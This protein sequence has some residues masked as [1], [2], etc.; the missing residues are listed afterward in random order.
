M[1]R[2][3]ISRVKS[4]LGT[5]LDNRSMKKT[6]TAYFFAITGGFFGLH[7]LY[8]GRT[9]QAL[10]WFTTLGGFG[11]GLLYEL[12]FSIKKYVQEANNDRSVHDHYEKK[13]REQKSPAFELIRFCGNLTKVIIYHKDNILSI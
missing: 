12:I 4:D 8:L 9:Q 6:A 7:H 5:F 13:M 2:N 11:V 1:E 3:E 10:L